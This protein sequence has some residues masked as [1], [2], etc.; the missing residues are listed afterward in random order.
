MFHF[1]SLVLKLNSLFL[2]SI[3][4]EDLVGELEPLLK[5]VKIPENQCYCPF[6][7]SL[8]LPPPNHES[9]TAQLFSK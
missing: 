7:S 6:L 8:Q 3:S 9:Q 2:V 5:L 1:F 4:L